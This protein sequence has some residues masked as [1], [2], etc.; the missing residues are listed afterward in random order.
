VDRRF[1]RM[2][3]RFDRMA[4]RFDRMAD[5]FDRMADGFDRMAAK[6]L[7]PRRS[8]RGRRGAPSPTWRSCRSRR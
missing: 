6:P 4:D 2:D 1:D 7:R 5:G 8:S 3:D